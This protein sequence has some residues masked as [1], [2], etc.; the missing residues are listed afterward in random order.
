MALEE[1][2]QAVE[3]RPWDD[4]VRLV[5]ADALS[6]RGDEQGELISVQCALTDPRRDAAELDV[7][8][9]RAVAAHPNLTDVDLGGNAI[10]DEGAAALSAMPSLQVL[11]LA[12]AGLSDG[13]IDPL[14]R[15]RLE[16]VDLR[17]NRF[18]DAG[19]ARLR[20]RFGAHAMLSQ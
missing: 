18:S 4:E 13:A 7:L 19:R 2:H 14:V 10:G 15:S 16:W 8:G 17:G 9:A 3:D 5:L 6:E 20:E 11:R 1:L 12:H